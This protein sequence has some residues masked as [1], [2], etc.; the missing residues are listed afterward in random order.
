MRHFGRAHLVYDF[1]CMI[2]RN[3]YQLYKIR[4]HGMP[5]H[6]G[7]L[8]IDDVARGTAPAHSRQ[9]VATPTLTMVVLCPATMLTCCS[10]G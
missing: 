4:R 5:C 3:V 10:P 9:L 2:R 1:Q 8:D 6:P 7:A